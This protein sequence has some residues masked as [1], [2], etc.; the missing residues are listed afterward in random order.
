MTNP[1]GIPGTA[2]KQWSTEQP[3][4]DVKW[5]VNWN[6]GS[7]VRAIT[8]EKA[9]NGRIDNINPENLNC[10]CT[11]RDKLK[12]KSEPWPSVWKISSSKLTPKDEYKVRA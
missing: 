8:S 3:R 5:L 9:R 4:F 2:D 10:L 1:I 11:L 12:K 7:R 6:A